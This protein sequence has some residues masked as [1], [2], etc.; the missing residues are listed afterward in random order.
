M[1]PSYSA[2]THGADRSERSAIPTVRYARREARTS[3]SLGLGAF[4]HS[5]FGES[6]G[7]CR[8]L[9][10][11]QWVDIDEQ[12]I[13]PE[14][15]PPGLLPADLAARRGRN[16]SPG[17]EV[18]VGSRCRTPRSRWQRIASTIVENARARR[19]HSVGRLRRATHQ[20]FGAVAGNR[21]RD[22]PADSRVRAHDGGLDVL[23]ID[24]SAVDDDQVLDSTRDEELTGPDETEI[25]RCAGTRVRRR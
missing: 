24:V 19:L 3:R 9:L 10:H 22:S 12:A 21:E 7:S 18:D 11:C 4:R 15:H 23:R 13:A 20:L 14:E 5:A 1:R 16:R 8:A 6:G 25:T 17:T 2:Y